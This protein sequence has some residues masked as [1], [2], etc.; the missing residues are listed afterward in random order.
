MPIVKIY[1]QKFNKSKKF[2]S[3]LNLLE[4]P[5]YGDKISLNHKR[6]IVDK[7]T[8]SNGAIEILVSKIKK[9]LRFW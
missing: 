2:V 5:E 6:Y 7:V 8:Q 9:T 4:I 1:T 3:E